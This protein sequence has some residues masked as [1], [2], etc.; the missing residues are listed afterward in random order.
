MNGMGQ[1]VYADK[2]DF[3]ENHTLNI[4]SLP[5]GLYFISLIQNDVKVTSKFIKH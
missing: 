4:S 2:L 1:L 3:N 5:Q